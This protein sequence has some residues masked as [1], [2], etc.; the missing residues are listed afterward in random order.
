MNTIQD[1]GK[2]VEQSIVH[3]ILEIEE[4]IK[5]QQAILDIFNSNISKERQFRIF[6]N[7]LKSSKKKQDVLDILHQIIFTK[8]Q[9]YYFFLLL[10]EG[11]IIRGEIQTIK[12]KDESISQI[13]LNFLNFFFSEHINFFTLFFFIF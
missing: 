11:D 6:Y 8:E 9:N 2:D 4:K 13:Y 12:E 10:F 1:I 3:N 5:I 7:I